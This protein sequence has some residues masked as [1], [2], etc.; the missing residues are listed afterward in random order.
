MGPQ[1]TKTVCMSISWAGPMAEL[2]LDATVF[3]DYRTGH[4]GARSVIERIMSGQITASIS[5]FTVFELWGN[6]DMDRRT[7][8]GYVGMLRFLE[9]ASLSHE[10]AKVAGIWIAPLEES[11]RIRLARYAL[12]AATA[13]ERGEPICTRDTEPFSRFISEVVGY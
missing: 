7:E 13:R 5:P 8:I 10:A 6:S 4:S 2:M 11:E 3:H 9:E 1:E 12:V